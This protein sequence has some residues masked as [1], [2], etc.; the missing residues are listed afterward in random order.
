MTEDTSPQTSSILP[1]V[2]IALLAVGIGLLGFLYYRKYKQDQRANRPLGLEPLAMEPLPLG[3]I[4]PKGWILDQLKLQAAGLSGHLDEFWPDV[5][6][7]GWFGG[8]GEGWERA[9]YWLDGAIPLAY[10]TGDPKL[11]AKVTKHIDYILAHAQKDGWLGPQTIRGPFGIPGPPPDSRDPW[12]QFVILKALAQYQEATGDPRILPAIGRDLAALA[13]QLEQ[14]SLYD[15]NFFRYGDLLTTLF[16]Y[17]DRTHEPAALALAYRAAS[18]GYNWPKHFEDL[19]IKEKSPG[20]NWYSHVVNNAMGLKV[21]A[22]LWRLTDQDEFKDLSPKAIGELDKYHGE[23]NGLFSGDEC[24]AGRS[25]SQGTELC[26]IVETMYSL[27]TQL[28]ILGGCAPADRLEKIAF[29]ALPAAISPDYWGHQYDEQAN[30]VACVFYQQ[31]VYTT[32]RGESNLF[33]LQPQYGCCTAN[34]HQGWPK[35]VSHLW[36]GTPDGGLA[37]VAYAPCAVTARVAGGNV[38]IELETQYPFSEDLTFTV[39]SG[40]GSDFPLYLRIPGWAKGASVTLPDGKELGGK[41][42]KY[43]KIARRWT[44][45]ERVQLHLPMTFKIHRG[46]EDSVSVE[47]GP[48]VYSLGL[49]EVWKQARPFPFQTKD[50]KRFDYFVLPQTA[51]NYALQLDTEHP[52]KSLEIQVTALSGDPF[53]L[54]DVPIHVRARG[55]KLPDWA[56]AQGAALPPP[57]SPVASTEPLEDLVLVPYGSARLRVTEFP[58]LKN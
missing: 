28:S 33:G 58:L 52:E 10:L 50:K 47:R 20:W 29:N 1:K 48:L 57:Q 35:F 15:W 39:H 54:S 21:P 42:G 17:Y 3:A 23:P 14:K 55:R 12:P 31:P 2:L 5:A 44:G 25:P 11:I 22:L 56:F 7:S 9:P 45:D 13:S 43:L 51:W 18:Q 32:N 40:S 49:P 36:M 46:Y 30:Q 37:A 27:E 16:W 34:F 24:L 53:T 41:A 6:K 4:K 19:P 8:D 26:A 38:S